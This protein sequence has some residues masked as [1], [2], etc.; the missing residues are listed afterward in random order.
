MREDGFELDD[1]IG[2]SI[3]RLPRDGRLPDAEP[4]PADSADDSFNELWGGD[5]DAIELP[6]IAQNGAEDVPS[7]CMGYLPLEIQRQ[8]IIR[9][10]RRTL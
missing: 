10:F 3:G 4:P 9:D 6:Q 5:P 7:V 8:L 2:S 1:V